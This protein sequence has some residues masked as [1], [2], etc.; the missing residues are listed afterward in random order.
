M[1]TQTVTFSAQT[2]A[3]KIESISNQSFMKQTV[4]DRLNQLISKKK[5]RV[6]S[7]AS[8]KSPTSTYYAQGLKLSYNQSE[9]RRQPFEF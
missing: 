3:L 5:Y 8:R 1:K 2:G 7:S 6:G 9:S 4:V